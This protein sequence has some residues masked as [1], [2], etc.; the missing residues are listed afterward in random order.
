MRETAAETGAAVIDDPEL[1]AMLAENGKI[2]KPIPRDSF[3]RAAQVLVRAGFSGLIRADPGCRQRGNPC[4]RSALRK[5]NAKLCT[6]A[7]CSPMIECTRI[8][9]GSRGN[10]SQEGRSGCLTRN[11]SS[12]SPRKRKPW[13]PTRLQSPNS[14]ARRRAP[15]AIAIDPAIPSY[16]IPEMPSDVLDQAR[17]ASREEAQARLNAYEAQARRSGSWQSD[18]FMLQG[19]MDRTAIQL[20]RL[21]RY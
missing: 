5:I 19:M 20:E 13:G 10:R 15:Q 12:F 4:V 3:T 9:P 2:G 17:A 8:R 18:G 16:V 1:F 7:T 11:F 6:G 21:A 14:S